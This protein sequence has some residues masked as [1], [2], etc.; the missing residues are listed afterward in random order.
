MVRTGHRHCT[1]RPWGGSSRVLVESV[2]S[3]WIVVGAVLKLDLAA[4]LLAVEAARRCGMEARRRAENGG[5][6]SSLTAKKK[7]ASRP[8]SRREGTGQCCAMSCGGG[9]GSMVGVVL[10]RRCG[11]SR[12]RG[13]GGERRSYLDRLVGR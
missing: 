7:L 5:V 12:S 9:M 3:H 4:Q 2:G 8:V 13:R 11:R 6:R 1:L 10:Q